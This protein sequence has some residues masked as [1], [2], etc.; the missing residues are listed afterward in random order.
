[1]RI[2]Y[3]DCGM[4][5][6]GDMLSA[7]LYDL[8]TESDKEAF[9]SEIN[10]IGIPDVTVVAERA[11]KCGITGTHMSV[12]VSGV[13]EDEHLH[14]H[15]HNHNHEDNHEHDHAHDHERSHDHEHHHHA[16]LHD[17]ESIVMGLGVADN[18]KSNVINIYKI[19]A[20]AESYVHG[21]PVTD[22]HFHEVG[23][24][25]AIADIVAVCMLMDRLAPDKI[26]ASAVNVGSG[27]V[28]CAHGILPVPAPATAHI[29]TGIPTYSGQITSELCTPTGAA[30]LKYF[31]D[32][33]SQMPVIATQ[34]IGYGMGKKD[35]PVA[36]CVR[37]FLGESMEPDKRS[38]TT[39][40][41]VTELTFNVDDMTG[42]AIGFAMNCLLD[43]GA[44]EVFTT[45]VNMK[46]NRPGIMMSV[47]CKVP[48][49]QKM[50]ELI[51]KHTTTIGVRERE[52]NRYVLDRRIE[53]VNTSLGR[54]RRKV[55]EGYGVERV[56]Y[57]YEDLAA[58]AL[59]HDMSL[60][61]VVN[62]VTSD[63][64]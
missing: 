28:K 33:F 55:S 19:I 9:I 61:D 21:V 56:K 52:Y 49:K 50:L 13:E 39:A 5:A 8:L 26:I 32:D 3:I 1:M 10:T 11:V 35:F 58:I 40:N 51:F 14:D 15:E 6:A 29:L 44:L 37:V 17:I 46:K 12:R 24:M 45:P 53:T 54:V 64:D 63:A 4:G 59:E 47:I 16:S 23:T 48:D 62:V 22:I 41:Q 27:T 30:V 2:I 34:N 7:A 43:N 36:N 38:D 60:T 25:D 20:E 18:I 57:E 31:V 42:E